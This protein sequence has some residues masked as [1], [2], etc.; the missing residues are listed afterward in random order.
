MEPAPTP[1][2]CAFHPVMFLI[3]C[4]GCAMVWTLSFETLV[5]LVLVITEI[6]GDLFA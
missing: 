5:W 4:L 1:Q 6:A 2:G 3:A